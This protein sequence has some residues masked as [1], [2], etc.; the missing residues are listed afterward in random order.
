MFIFLNIMM[1]SFLMESVSKKRG[2]NMKVKKIAFSTAISEKQI[3]IYDDQFAIFT[4]DLEIH[5]SFP[6]EIK[7][8]IE[9]G[10]FN[11]DQRLKEAIINYILDNQGRKAF[12]SV[13]DIVQ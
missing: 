13:P 3:A 6:G 5:L 4:N 7:E 12:I 1:G 2:I 9:N 10:E 11:N 8:R